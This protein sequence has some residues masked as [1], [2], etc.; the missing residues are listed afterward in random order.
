[1][2]RSNG[3]RF[4]TCFMRKFA[5]LDAFYTI[6]PSPWSLDFGFHAFPDGFLA[7]FVM[8]N[9]RHLKIKNIFAQK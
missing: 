1:M 2:L 6:E 7:L 9:R 3:E 8:R 5:I 4:G